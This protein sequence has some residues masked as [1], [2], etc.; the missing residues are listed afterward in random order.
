M[1]ILT[2][3]ETFTI[4]GILAVFFIFNEIFPVVS[5]QVMTII[6]MVAGALVFLIYRGFI[7][8]TTWWYFFRWSCYTTRWH[9]GQLSDWLRV[10]STAWLWVNLASPLSSSYSPQSHYRST[11]QTASHNH[12]NLIWRKQSTVTQMVPPKL[13]A[14]SVHSLH[15]VETEAPCGTPMEDLLNHLPTRSVTDLPRCGECNDTLYCILYW[16]CIPVHQTD[17]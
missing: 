7:W 8:T 15:G 4:A 16:I 10:R 11:L 5:Q 13:P 12:H 9:C 6:A 14:R 2:S 3:T 1:D 17:G